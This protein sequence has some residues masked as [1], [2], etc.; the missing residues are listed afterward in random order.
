MYTPASFRIDDLAQLHELMEQSPLATLITA[1]EQGLIASHLPVLLERQADN[2]GTLHGH[3]AR[4]NPQWRDLSGGVEVLAV[5]TGA[6]AYVSPG[7]Y[8]SKARDHKAVPTWNYIAVHAWGRP[9]VFDD[10]VRL[11]ELVRMLSD[12]HERGQPQPWSLDD[13]P[14]DYLDAML[15]AI[16]GFSLPIERIEGKWKLSQN[17]P[18]DNLAGVRDALAA[19]PVP[20]ESEVAQLMSSLR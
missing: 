5:F 4:A 6:S 16:V 7:Y 17:Q 8:P 13:A 20:S 9:E 19:S 18:T 10:P 15:R 2:R 1:G 11:R 3:F 12:N 14:A